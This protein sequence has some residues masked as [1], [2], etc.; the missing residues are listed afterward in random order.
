MTPEQI[1]TRELSA[2]SFLDPYKKE[3]KR[4]KV[5]INKSVAKRKVTKAMKKA[6]T[7]RMRKNGGNQYLA[8][9]RVCLRYLADH[10]NI[11]P[12]EAEFLVWA[13]AYEY[14]TIKD[15]MSLFLIG[16]NLE[17]V[18]MNLRHKGLVV[19]MHGGYRVEGIEAKWT[20]HP[21]AAKFITRYVYGVLEERIEFPSFY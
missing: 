6:T 4:N 11:K 9:Y 13:H 19:K 7:S 2:R 20:I 1:K 3:G 10:Y 21:N 5:K 14:Y 15:A 17:R 16:R 8:L 18:N 12:V